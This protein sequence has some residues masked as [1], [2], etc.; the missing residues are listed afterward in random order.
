MF[1]Y[2]N[3][4]TYFFSI[5]TTK[6]E[7]NQT[8]TKLIIEY[9]MTHFVDKI[10]NVSVFLSSLFHYTVVE[11]GMHGYQTKEFERLNF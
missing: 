4:H 6:N 8:A 11:K 1:A 2:G 7:R 9:L 10:C 5:G 3:C